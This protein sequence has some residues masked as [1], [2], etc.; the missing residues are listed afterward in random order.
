MVGNAYGFYGAGPDGATLTQTLATT[1]GTQYTI[2][3]F[4]SNDRNDDTNNRLT[5]SF[6]G[7]TG[8]DQPIVDAGYFDFHS[9]TATATSSSTTLSFSGYNAAD[10]FASVDIDD[11]SVTAIT[12]APEPS[13]AALFGTGLIGL[14]GVV[15]RRRRT[16]TR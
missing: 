4:T 3:F 11:L 1:P 5:V 12:T 10:S 13:S 14:G 7:T 15:M 6:G 9:F 8:F 16:A 2:G